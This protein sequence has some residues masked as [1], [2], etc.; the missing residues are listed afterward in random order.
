MEFDLN[1][2][3]RL[4]PAV[5]LRPE[6]FGACQGGCMAAKFFIGLPLDGPDPECVLGHGERE[7]AT[8]CLPDRPQPGPGHSRRQPGR[9]AP[10][11]VPVDLIA[12]R[13]AT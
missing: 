8:V 10:V 1:R 6:P 12:V 7:L 2:G 3:W 9:S 11:F 5:A 13:A 4:N